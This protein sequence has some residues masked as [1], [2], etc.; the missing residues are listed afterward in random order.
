[1]GIHRQIVFRKRHAS[2]LQLVAIQLAI[3]NQAL[4]ISHIYLQLIDQETTSSLVGPESA[5]RVITHSYKMLI[6]SATS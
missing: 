2:R 1:M 5:Q 3:S 4:L 6:Y